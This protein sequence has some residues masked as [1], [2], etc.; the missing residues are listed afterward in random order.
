MTQKVARGH[1]FAGK[2]QHRTV[3]SLESSE[4][5]VFFTKNNFFLIFFGFCVHD[6][7]TRPTVVLSTTDGQNA[8]SSTGG[9]WFWYTDIC[10]SVKDRGL[11][12]NIHE[13]KISIH[14]INFS[15][16]N[17]FPPQNLTF[18]HFRAIIY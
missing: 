7:W 14:E 17:K 16:Q 10:P 11:E 1:R 5:Q 4:K 9:G 15:T 3:K 6:W 12:T 2:K 13:I 8:G 18:S